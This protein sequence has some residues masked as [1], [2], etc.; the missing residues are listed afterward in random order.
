MAADPGRDG[1][2]LRAV[3]PAVGPP[4][5]RVDR[6][7]RVLEPEA[8]RA[9]PRGRRRAGRH[10]CGRDRTRDKAPGRR[11]RRRARPPA[12]EARFKPSTKTL[13]LSARPSPSVSSRIL[14]RSA[15]RGPRGGGSGTRSYSVRRYWSTVTGLSPAGL[16]YCKYSTTQSRPRS[17]KQ[18]DHR[19]ADHRLGREDLDVKPRRDHHPPD[20]LLGREPAGSFGL[21]AAGARAR[22][23]RQEQGPEHEPRR[24]SI[25]RR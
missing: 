16:G 2:P 18:A 9:G 20:R 23:G 22:A 17:S 6:R 3:E 8:G 19:L 24:Q 5:H 14:I 4:G 11:T 21:L 15:P 12:P 25:H 7:V 1:A 13:T 10:G